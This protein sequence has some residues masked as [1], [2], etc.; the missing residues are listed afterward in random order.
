MTTSPPSATPNLLQRLWATMGFTGERQWVYPLEARGTFTRLHHLT[1]A[2]LFALLFV[3]PWLRYNGRP[4][5][6]ADLGSRR[7]YVLDR[8]FSASDGVLLMWGGLSAVFLLFFVTAGLGR[9]WCGYACPQSVFLINL[10]Y[11][12]ERWIEG[13]RGRRKSRD[14]RGF[15]V[16]TTGRK[17]LKFALFFA[18]AL[19]VSMSFMGFFVRTEELWTGQASR[20]AY[21]VV[22]FFTLLWF[23][24][25]AWFREQVCNRVCPYARFQGALTDDHSL[26]IAYD[27]DRGEPRG[28]E[29]KARGGCI[30][31]LKCVAVCPQGI[32]IR[33]GFQLECI[34]CGKCVDACTSVMPRIGFPTLVHYTTERRALGK[35]SRPIRARTIAYAALLTFSTTGLVSTV[36]R[37]V[38]L[39][40]MVDR[41]PGP[42]FVEDAD[43]YVRNTYM[44]GVT[45]LDLRD[46]VRT[47]AIAFEGLPPHSQVRASPVQLRSAEQQ[48]VPVVVRIPTAAADRTLQLH[49]TVRG[50]DG[51][52][53]SQDTTFKGP[54]R[55]D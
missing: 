7:L 49:V 31:C 55:T 45:D 53:R 8:M 12:I 16:R 54:G 40:V 35:R 44:V 14:G 28:R 21:L 5:F 47:Y 24:D 27:T 43:G 13:A 20:G 3:T 23:W 46:G 19:F 42:L 37:H 11:P 9:V 1:S 4:L 50:A 25:F 32:D 22:A 10:V 33:D 52:S 18:I 39:E 38:P 36:A 41:A 34:A 6:L 15:T 30:D 17:G 26:V 2:A 51:V 29:A 48:R